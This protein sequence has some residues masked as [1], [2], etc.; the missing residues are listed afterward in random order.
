QYIMT[1]NEDS[2]FG[3]N[4]ANGQAEEAFKRLH[5][6]ERIQL[7]GIHCHIGS[8]IFET[9]GYVIATK[10][11]FQELKRW[12]ESYDYFPRVINLGGGFGIRYTEEDTPLPYEHYVEKMIEVVQ[13]HV[14]EMNV[15]FPEIWIEPGRSIAGDAG[16]TLYTIGATKDIP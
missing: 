1:G 13:K 12:N 4:L 15:P 8:Q 10:V 11:L 16:L 7:K 2:K 6:H 5:T 14:G 3:F 9:E